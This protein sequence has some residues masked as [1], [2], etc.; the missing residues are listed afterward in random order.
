M[1]LGMYNIELEADRESL[2]KF[3]YKVWS[4]NEHHCANLRVQSASGHHVA[5]LRSLYRQFTSL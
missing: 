4:A 5:N 3:I 1:S 2:N